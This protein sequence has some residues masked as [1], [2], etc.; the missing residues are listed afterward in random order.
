MTSWQI[1]RT[2]LLI[3]AGFFLVGGSHLSA[4]N[5]VTN[6]GFESGLT[7][8]TNN[9]SGGAGASFSLETVQPYEGARA[10][11]IAVTN[12]GAQLHNVQTQGPTFTL[13]VGTSTSITFRARASVPGVKVRF[14]MQDATYNNKEFTLS[15]SWQWFSW[16]HTTT[17]ATP[18][19]RMQYRSVGTVWL[20]DISLVVNAAAG[21]TTRISSDTTIRHQTMDG[22]GG[23]IAFNTPDYEALS[24]T[25]KNE[26]ENLLYVNCGID[27]VRLRTGNSDAL[28]N[29]LAMRAQRNGAK[30]LLTCWSPPAS[31]KSNNSIV[32]GTLRIV[33]GKYDYA[34]FADWWYARLSA[35]NWMHDFISIQ[36]EPSYDPGDKETCRF[37]ANETVPATTSGSASYRLA[38]DAVYN[39]IKNEP[40]R[41]QFIAVDAETHSAFNSIA[42]TVSALSYVHHLGFHNYG[43]NDFAGVKSRYNGNRGWM[44]EWGADPDILDNWLVLA[45]NIHETLVNANASAYLAW[46][47]VHGNNTGQVWAMI[48]VENGQYQVQNSFYSVKHF[49]KHISSGDQ[50]I[51]VTNSGTNANL[52]VSGYL[53]V[54]GNKINLIVLNTGGTDDVISLR[55]PGLPV[56]SVTAF[57]TRQFDIGGFPYNSLGAI[58]IANNQTISKNSITS[59]VVNLTETINPYDPSLL[60]VD[61]FLKQGNQF[62]LAIPAQ[63]GHNFTLWKSSSLADGSWQEVTN[64]VRAE[65]DGQLYLT[66]PNAGTTRAFYRVE[67]DTGL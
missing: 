35:S 37:F 52:R 34:G 26:I 8:W 67:R 58:N 42:P 1:N 14:V 28:N 56:G 24:A 41:P 64:A 39:K 16:N 49:A 17:E 29:E 66:D 45:T 36:N 63:P 6:G 11:K 33:S 51:E 19:L 31:L 48:G 60:R 40:K 22:I 47:M 10:M 15:T 2:F 3:F 4:Q 7:G 21:T 20:D 54:A 23:S 57:R 61:G 5:L 9:T 12:P 13:A 46:R 65:I 55:F 43:T 59:Y 25:K 44:T 53:N 32:S 27:I 38:M 62:S 30:S 50:R 18:R